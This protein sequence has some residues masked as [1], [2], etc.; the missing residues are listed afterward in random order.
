MVV[1]LHSFY[2]GRL[3]V[4]DLAAERGDPA[5]SVSRMSRRGLF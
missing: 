3:A 1:F 2:V 5:F 4:A